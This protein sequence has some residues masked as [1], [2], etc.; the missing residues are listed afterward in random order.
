M[1]N[2][3]LMADVHFV[4]GQSGGTQMLPGHKV[5]PLDL[6][7]TDTAA[8][9]GFRV[10]LTAADNG[11]QILSVV[12]GLAGHFNCRCKS[13]SVCLFLLTHLDA[14]FVLRV[15]KQYVTKFLNFI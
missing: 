4:V 10:C 1:F 5:S 8:A 15:I 2:N 13:E 6:Q 7:Q 12:F 3:E 11:T 9:S 14:G